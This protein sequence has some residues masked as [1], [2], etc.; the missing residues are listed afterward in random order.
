MSCTLFAFMGGRGSNID[1]GIRL[2]PQMMYRSVM[3][4]TKRASCGLVRF[5][6]VA[7]QP[8]AS[9]NMERICMYFAANASF[10]VVVVMVHCFLSLLSLS[11]PGS[12]GKLMSHFCVDTIIIAAIMTIIAPIIVGRHSVLSVARMKSTI[13]QSTHPIGIIFKFKV[14]LT[15]VLIITNI[16]VR[17]VS[18]I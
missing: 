5:S 1:S 9:S 15:S 11:F 13:I 14:S 3:K 17:A 10:N 16:V 18:Y 4:L 6:Y 12:S 2:S 8:F 7:G